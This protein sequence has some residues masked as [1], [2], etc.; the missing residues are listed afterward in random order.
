MTIVHVQLR[1]AESGTGGPCFRSRRRLIPNNLALRQQ[2]GVLKRRQARPKLSPF[3]K[4]FWVLACLFW[5]DWRRSLLLV[6][7]ETVVRWHRAG[8]RLYWSLLS[9]A[10]K[11][12]GRKKLPMEVRELIFR[13]VPEN[14]RTQPGRLAFTKSFSCWALRYP[15]EPSPAE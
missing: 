5:T 1:P 7:P 14:R 13:M 2:L 3:Y 10:R 15:R 4:L 9:K 8:F 12:L 11:Q 6:T